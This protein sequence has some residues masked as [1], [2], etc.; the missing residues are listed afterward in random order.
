MPNLKLF[1]LSLQSC[2]MY[3][4]WGCT[5]TNSLP[6]SLTVLN[7]SSP[8]FFMPSNQVPPGW[9]LH[10]TMYSWN[11]RYNLGFL[12]NTDLCALRKY[13]PDDFTLMMLGYSKIISNFLAPPNNHWFS[14]YLPSLLDNKARSKLPKLLSSTA[15]WSWNIAPLLFHI[16][17]QLLFSNSFTL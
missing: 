9:L 4:N 3:C 12:W 7:C 16:I 5:F 17:I 1:A 6:L 14:Y 2:N 10:N 11:T 15:C 13:P 8:G